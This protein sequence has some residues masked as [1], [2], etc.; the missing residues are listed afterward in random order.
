MESTTYFGLPEHHQGTPPKELISNPPE[1]CPHF[2]AIVGYK[3]NVVV[4]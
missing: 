1:N 4:R 3:R 2:P